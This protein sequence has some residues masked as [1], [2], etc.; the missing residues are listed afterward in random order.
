MCVLH[1][2]RQILLKLSD[3]KLALGH[4]EVV[5]TAATLGAGG[6]ATRASLKRVTERQISCPPRKAAYY[7]THTTVRV[8]TNL[9]ID[10][11]KVEKARRSLQRKARMTAAWAGLLPAHAAVVILFLGSRTAGLSQPFRCR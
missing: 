4:Y 6:S 9:L 5:L 2:E 11:E 7:S 10:S 8:G 3:G 1:F